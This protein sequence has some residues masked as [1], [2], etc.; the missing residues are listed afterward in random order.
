MTQSIFVN[1]GLSM[2]EDEIFQILN[3]RIRAIK[4]DTTN[5]QVLVYFEKKDNSGD[6]NTST[7]EVINLDVTDGKES[8]AAEAIISALNGLARNSQIAKISDFNNSVDGV[9]GLEIPVFTITNTD[10]AISATATDDF[11][12]TLASAQAGCDFSATLSMDDDSHTFTKTGTNITSTEA[13]KFDST[14]FSAGAAT[15]E[16][17]LTNP[18]Q[19]GVTRVVSKAATITS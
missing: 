13:I 11:T 17:T 14:D 19:P 1:S 2:T 18:N 3:G 8:T 16:I 7:S 5:N 12:F 10:V 4:A 15:I 9:N 6:T